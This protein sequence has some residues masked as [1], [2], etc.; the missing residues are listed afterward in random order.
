MLVEFDAIDSWMGP[1]DDRLRPHLP[2]DVAERI[3]ALNPRY[4]EDARDA[5]LDVGDRDALVD[6]ALN[7]ISENTL[8]GFH[9]TRLTDQEVQAVLKDGLTPLSAGMR[10]ERLERALSVHPR[11]SEC[12]SRLEGELSR[13]GADGYAG[14]REGQ[15]HLTLSRAGLTESF[16]HYLEFGAEF[17]QHVARALLDEEGLEC[18]A[19]DGEPRLISVAVPG[20]DAIAAAN[21][22]FSVAMMR[23]RDELPNIVKEFLQS[24]AFRLTRPNFQS[25]RLELDCGMVFRSAVPAAWGIAVE[26]LRV[27]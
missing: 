12:A 19:R 11:W 6:A 3:A 20:P 15:V 14:V 16:N 25:R 9:G 26:T 22:Y 27:S 8:A 4:V 2:P 23:E 18:L 1:L 21:P 10:K 24:F 5:L 7:W 17:D 13:H